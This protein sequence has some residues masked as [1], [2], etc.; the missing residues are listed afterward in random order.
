MNHTSFPLTPS[1]SPA[2]A[3]EGDIVRACGAK[4][5]WEAA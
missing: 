1:P 5:E 4:L 3:S 2:I